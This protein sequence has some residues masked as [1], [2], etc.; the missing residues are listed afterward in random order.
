M[1]CLDCGNDDIRYDEHEKSYH[2]N[3]CGSRNLGTRKEG[4][5]WMKRNGLCGKTPACTSSGRCEGHCSYF[6]KEKIADMI[7]ERKEIADMSEFMG[8]YKPYNE[9]IEE[10]F[11]KLYQKAENYPYDDA[12]WEDYHTGVCKDNHYVKRN[13]VDYLIQIDITCDIATLYE[14]RKEGGYKKWE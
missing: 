7:Y 14:L 12:K 9:H 11:D 4:C 5:M 6:E 3:N 8:D 13:N 1:I 2:C 10:L